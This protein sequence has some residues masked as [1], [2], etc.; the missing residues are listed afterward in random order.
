MKICKYKNNK[1]IFYFILIIIQIIYIKG[2]VFYF[3]VRL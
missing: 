1:F 2:E 3:N